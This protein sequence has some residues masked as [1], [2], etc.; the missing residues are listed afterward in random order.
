M[1]ELSLHEAI[2]ST[3]AMRRLKP[4][5]VPNADLQYII[6][7]ATMAPSGGNT[8]G[9]AFIVVTDPEVRRRL[10]DIYQEVGRSLFR[11]QVLARDDLPDHTRRVYTNALYLVDHIHDAPVLIVP[12]LRSR[13]PPDASHASGYYGSIYPAIQNLMLA[14]RAR[15]LGTTLTT[16]HKQRE[17]QV[18]EVLGL[19][20]DVET[21]ALIPLG[22]P[23]G[24]WGRPLRHPSSQVTH[25]DRWGNQRDGA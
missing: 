2:F 4:D 1:H 25:W 15:G 19:P 23:Q 13:P 22:Y 8:Q 11:D 14:A 5:P 12:C 6:E 16:V 10:A 21:V 18:R 9:W 24:K 17:E 7:A 20:D 3:R